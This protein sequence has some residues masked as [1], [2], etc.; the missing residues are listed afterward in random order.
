MKIWDHFHA[1]VEMNDGQI[2]EVEGGWVEFPDNWDD[3][4]RWQKNQ[5][6]LQIIAKWGQLSNIKKLIR[7]HLG[8]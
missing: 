5:I 8:G 4:E 7:F 2:E 3:M 1:E 6:V